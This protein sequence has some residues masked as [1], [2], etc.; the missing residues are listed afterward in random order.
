[1]ISSF[2]KGVSSQLKN[3]S[4]TLDQTNIL[5]DKPWALIDDEFE[6]Q[7]LIFKRDGEL[8]LSRNG[9][10]T[11]GSW[12][13]FPQAKSLLIDRGGDKILCNEAYIDSSVMILKLDGS[14]NRF[15]LFANEN[16]IPNLDAI[17]YLKGLR[18][19]R[20]NIL[21]KKLSDG[22]I[23][24]IQRAWSLKPVEIGDRVTIEAEE[25]LDGNY[26]IGENGFQYYVIEN[27]SI[28]EI[29]F[30]RKYT[31]SS[32]DA[33]EIHQREKEEGRIGH[34]DY[35]FINGTRIFNSTID[36]SKR[37]VLIVENGIIIKVQWKNFL[38]RLI[39]G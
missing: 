33:V 1:M 34:G 9:K 27:G 3:Y 30:R 31:I 20:L 25:V 12:E 17:G 6:V 4:A 21:E 32:G 36:F 37:K 8:V 39:N 35:L 2:L 7:K 19:E 14:A 5:S 16:Q 24:E 13:Y 28:S 29:L 15:F 38:L 10:V 18:K 22:R 26:D 11:L 23:I